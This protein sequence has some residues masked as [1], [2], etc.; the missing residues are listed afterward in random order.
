MSN[1][2]VSN[3]IPFERPASHP[4]EKTDDQYLRALAEQ[5]RNH[6]RSS[7]KAIIAIGEALRDAKQHLGHGKFGEWVVAECGFTIRTAQN[8][9][10]AADLT[11]KSE[12]VS[13]LSPAAIYRLAKPSTPPDVVTRVLEMLETGDIPTEL[14]IVAL[15][16]RSQEADVP[17]LIADSGAVAYLA[18]ELHARLGD[19]LISQLLRS[20]WP[21]LRK[22]LRDTIEQSNQSPKPRAGQAKAPS[23]QA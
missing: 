15:T 11:D 2:E 12:I 20:R 19:E 8:Y 3:V 16:P 7:T 14:E 5:V 6:S 4:E 23:N 18:R 9:M 10:R 13:L 22:H 1:S 17:G 21:D